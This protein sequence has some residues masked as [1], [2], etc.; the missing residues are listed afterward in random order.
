MAKNYTKATMK[1][2]IAQKLKN[3]FSEEIHEASREQIYE[4]CCFVIRD[5][6]SENNINYENEI[7]ENSERQV[8]YLSMEFLMG[9]SLLNNA[10]NLGVLK[11]MKAALKDLGIDINDLFESEKDPGLGNG[12]LGRLAACFMDSMATIGVRATGYTIRYKYGIFKQKIV[13]GEQVELPDRWLSTGRVWQ[14]PS[15]DESREVRIGGRIEEHWKNGKLKVIHKDY[16]TI[17]ATPYD[18]IVSGYGTENIAKLK[19][20]KSKSPKK[21]DMNLFSRGEYLKSCEEN[22]MA[23]AISMILYPEDNHIEG[24]SLRLKQQYFLV[25][26]T[27]QDI[28]AK[29]K[30]QYGTLD[31]FSQKHVIH[32]NDTHPVLAIPELMRILLDEEDMSWEKAWNIVSH[33][34]AYT[35]HTVLQEALECWHCDLVKGLLPRI[36]SIII[37]LNERF[38]KDLWERYPGDFDRISNMAIIGDGFVRMANLAIYGSFSIN[39]VS[40][41]HTNILKNTVFNNFYKVYPSKFTNVTNGITHRRWLCQANP[42]LASLIEELIGDGFIKQPS[43]LNVL[44]KFKDDKKVLNKLQAIKK[45]NK[46]RLAKYIKETTGIEVNIN[47]IFD[48]QVKRLHEYKRQLLNILHILYLY[49]KIKDD[50]NTNIV[51]RTFIFASKS[52]PGY[53]IAKKIISLIISIANVINNDPDVGDKLKVV[54]IEDYK[55]SLAEIIIPAAEIS[56]QISIAGKEAS[57]TGNMKFMLNGAITLGTLDGANVEICEAVG[58]DN[59]F[60]FG[61]KADEVAKIKSEHSYSPTQIYQNNPEIARVLDQI[62][63]GF[64]DGKNYGDIVRILLNGNG[65]IPDEYMVLA[66]FESYKNAQKRVEEMYLRPDNWNY[67]SLMNIAN[68]GRFSS[69]RSIAEYSK[70]IWKVPT[71]FTF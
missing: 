51:P 46:E 9:R 64:G 56:E 70:N 54:F 34:I 17:V 52:A 71:K 20:W 30:Q 24:Q 44:T 28:V 32:I 45:E 37:E 63:N 53:H 7:E 43:Q 61:L 55:V 57:G 42:N 23:E 6:L 35:N 5:I 11:P 25:S 66:D 1:K 58:E 31:N 33:T 65:G 50:P 12:G 21:V 16:T 8:H 48:V 29:H 39:G 36:F 10:Y 68:S 18:T 41:L 27:I 60:I 40:E 38:C 26:A 3:H 22:A 4:A 2:E 14:I 62:A 67:M 13:D 59:I 19:L 69:D 49:N 15:M 47:S